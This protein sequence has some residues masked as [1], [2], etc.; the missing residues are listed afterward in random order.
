MSVGDKSIISF[1]NKDII[2]VYIPK[3]QGNGGINSTKFDVSFDF[4]QFHWSWTQEWRRC[5]YTPTGYDKK[6]NEMRKAYFDAKITILFERWCFFLT[7]LEN[8]S[9]NCP[10]MS[11]KK[12]CVV[13]AWR[14][15]IYIYIER[16]DT[17]I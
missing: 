8:Q 15:Y 2:N 11:T 10:V 6:Q 14:G 3:E 5:M 4:I 16:E 1:K 12:K 7:M 9:K 17:Y 13:V